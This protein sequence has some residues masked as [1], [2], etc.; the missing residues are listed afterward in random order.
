MVTDHQGRINIKGISRDGGVAQAAIPRTH[1]PSLEDCII[2]QVLLEGLRLGA[3][4]TYDLILGSNLRRLAALMQDG[5]SPV[6]LDQETIGRLHRQMTRQTA[7]YR[8]SISIIEILVAAQGLSLDDGKSDI[9]LP[10][11][12]LDMNRFFQALL[13]GFLRENIPGYTVVDE[14]R[15]SGMIS[16]VTGKNPRGTGGLQTPART[17]RS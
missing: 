1:H 11:F 6:R 8:S 5:I 14:H 7:A 9:L 3:R 10:G 13:S 16:Y 4:L 15:L 17:P 12:L 2:N